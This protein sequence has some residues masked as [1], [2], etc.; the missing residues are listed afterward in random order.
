MKCYIKESKKSEVYHELRE[1]ANI[2]EGFIEGEDGTTLF[3]LRAYG[4]PIGSE[5]FVT[6]WLKT[7]GERITS[8]MLEIGNL[9][10]PARIASRHIS[11]RQCL[12]LLILNCL[13]FKGNYL[14]EIYHLNLQKGSARHSTQR[15]TNSWV[16][17]LLRRV[18]SYQH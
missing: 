3:G 16:G 15:S 1:A 2:P 9:L 13:Q 14:S 10:D 8:N 4:V 11:S 7:K 17:A 12:W 5:V 6:E 18:K